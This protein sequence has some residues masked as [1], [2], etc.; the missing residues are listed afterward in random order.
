MDGNILYREYSNTLRELIMKR[1]FGVCL[2]VC[3]FAVSAVTYAA[4]PVWKV[5]F[6]DKITYIG[7]TVHLL[8]AEDH[9]L[10]DAF[11]TAYKQ[12][13]SLIFETDIDAASTPEFQAKMMQAMMSKD[14]RALKQTLKEG[15]YNKLS[16]YMSAR[17]SSIAQFAQFSPSGVCLMVAMMELQFMGQSPEWGVDVVYSRKAKLDGKKLAGLETVDEQLSFFTDM[18]QGDDDELVLYTLNDI[19][20]MKSY[21]QELKR[22]WR[23]GDLAGIDTAVS[24]DKDKFPQMHKALIADRNNNWVPKIEKMIKAE[25]T[26][27]I[28]FGAAHLSGKQGVIAQLKERGYKLEQ[29]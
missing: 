2:A 14:G 7:G 23:A 29:L 6:E 26:E 17:G 16:D 24:Q 11:E 3:I 5:T 10:P 27:F 4:A 13:A 25:G 8:A 1:I 15:T 9:P 20:K 12:S 28:L 19:D 22:V 18:G 21:I